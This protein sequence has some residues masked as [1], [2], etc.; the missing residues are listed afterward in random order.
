MKI[1][2]LAVI[3]LTLLLVGAG[4]VSAKSLYVNGNLNANSPISA[5]DIQ[6][7]NIV[8]QLT[9]TPT[10]YGGA[11]L[12]M[13]TDSETLFVSF[14]GSGTFDIV[15]AKT[16]AKMGQVTA[17]SAGNLA[18]IVVDQDKNK[19]Y[20]VN[21]G[22]TYIY[23]YSW[24]ASTKTLTL[25]KTQPLSG[26]NQIYGLALDEKTDILYVGDLTTT[27]KGYNTNTW[28]QVK[29][30]A[31][32]QSVM[33]IA[34]DEVRGYVYT[35][36]AYPPAGS[37]G[38]LSQYNLNTNTE[39]TINT[40]T[41]SGGVSTD[42]AVG[43]A[44]DLD[45]GLVYVTTGNQGDGGSDRILV[46]DTNLNVKSSTGDIGD[47]TGIVVPRKQISYNPLN[48]AKIGG[49]TSVL[50]GGQLTYTISFDNINNPNA[51]TGV[52]LTDTLPQEVDYVS[53]TGGGSYNAGVVT[54]NIGPMAAYAPSQTVTVTVKVKDTAPIGTYL[55]NAATINGAEA[56]TGPTT[57]HNRLT[58]IISNT[59]TNVPE[60]PNV[61]LPIAAI[62]G[63]MFVFG[64]RKE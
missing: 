6:G 38:L 32:S 24:D 60:F 56:G 39:K 64:R 22:Y 7:N 48:L 2:Y 3:V 51:V 8:F 30:F 36:N 46:L 41:L 43:I 45:T 15:N 9:S 18:G 55:D 54:W 52:T 57:V 25:D 10:R 5:Y 19:V 58:Q 16:L 23:I 29:T 27:V 4:T 59:N 14:E 33:G 42:N 28:N 53:C 31:V 50:Q 26:S 35:G 13:D 44:V 62:M 1:K 40:R 61:A 20:T 49:V 12:A 47:P 11:G 21:R 17:P 63:L 37:Q 34:V